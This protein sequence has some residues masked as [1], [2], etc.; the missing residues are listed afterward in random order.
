M[1]SPRET[2]SLGEGTPFGR[3]GGLLKGGSSGISATRFG[4]DQHPVK[5][6][7]Q[8]IQG[9]GNGLFSPIPAENFYLLEGVGG[10]V[11]IGVASE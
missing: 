10:G 8:Y 5:S 1:S 4:D 3:G 9:S 6:R 11:V 2:A 7:T